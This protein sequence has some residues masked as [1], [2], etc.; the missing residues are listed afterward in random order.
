MDEARA[1][2]LLRAQFPQWADLPLREHAENGTD[3][4]LF[5]LG[6]YGL[7][8]YANVPSMLRKTEQWIAYALAD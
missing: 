7:T 5:R 4:T 8:Y 1:R 2:E 3:H 6:C